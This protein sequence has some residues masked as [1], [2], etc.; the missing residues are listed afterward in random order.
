[1]S[2][3]LKIVDNDNGDVLLDSDRIEVLLGSFVERVDEWKCSC[4]MGVFV[5]AKVPA[6]ASARAALSEIIRE[7]ETRYPATKDHD[8]L[9]SGIAF[10]SEDELDAA[11]AAMKECDQE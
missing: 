11:L 7:I 6:I 10:S 1:M 9:L 4:N 3:T 8:K 5:S 2:Y